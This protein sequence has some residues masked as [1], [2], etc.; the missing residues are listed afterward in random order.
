MSVWSHL[1]DEFRLH[2]LKPGR[3]EQEGMQGPGIGPTPVFEATE[4]QPALSSSS[5]ACRCLGGLPQTRRP[6]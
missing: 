5:L 4:E 3:Q 2:F 6:G 1:E